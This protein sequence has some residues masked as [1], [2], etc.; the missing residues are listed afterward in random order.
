MEKGL[1]SLPSGKELIDLILSQMNAKRLSNSKSKLVSREELLTKIEE[2]LSLPSNYEI[3]EEGRI[4]V[5]S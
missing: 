5:I 4:W 1:H 2:L 3:K